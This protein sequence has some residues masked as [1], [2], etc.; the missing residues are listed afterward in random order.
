LYDSPEV[1][2]DT[3]E[4]QKVQQNKGAASG[5]NSKKAWKEVTK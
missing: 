4:R 3:K 5:F 2:N 1:N